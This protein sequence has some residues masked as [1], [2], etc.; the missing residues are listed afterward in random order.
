M[1]T[2]QSRSAGK[3]RG[4]RLT[5]RQ[6][7]SLTLALLAAVGLSVSPNALAGEQRWI[8]TWSASPVSGATLRFEDQT[9][10]EIVQVSLGGDRVRVRLTNAF[11]TEP[12]LIGEAHVARRAAGAAIVPGTDRTL[13]FGGKSTDVL[14]PTGAPALS[15]PVDLEV[16][17]Q[18]DL[19]ISIYL[20][21]NFGPPTVHGTA[22]QTSY[23]STA[24]NC[25]GDEVMPVAETTL[26]WYYLADFEVSAS[27]RA[28][29]IVTLGDSIT[30]GT[31]STPDTNRRWPNRLASRLLDEQREMGV[32]NQ[33]ISGNRILH[34]GTGPNALARFDRDVLAQQGVAYVVLLEAINDIGRSFTMPDEAVDAD[35]LINGYRQLIERAHLRRLKIIGGTLTPFEGAGYFSE[36]GEADRQAVNDFVRYGGEFDGVIDFDAAVRDP[37]APRRFLPDYDSGDHLHPNDAGYEAMAN[38]I[39]LSLFDD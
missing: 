26:S 16:P 30:D 39:D 13:S 32:L 12:L 38:A 9:L 2:I 8:G 15:D 11:G 22:S 25:T 33:G 20:G 24:G 5:R 17:A 27:E 21:G 23:I 14:I 29:A 18:S 4:A 28:R 10:R 6:F 7:S 36:Q 3:L 31:R 1:A 37:S 34:D 35:Q 19:A